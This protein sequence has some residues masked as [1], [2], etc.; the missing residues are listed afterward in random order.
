MAASF[1][2]PNFFGSPPL[3]VFFDVWHSAPES[4]RALQ[5]LLATWSGVFPQEVVMSIKKNLEALFP[6]QSQNGAGYAATVQVGGCLM[7]F[8][9][10]CLTFLNYKEF[11]SYLLFLLCKQSLTVNL[12]VHRRLCLS[13]MTRAWDRRPFLKQLQYI[14]LP[15]R[16]SR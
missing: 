1:A 11:K 9:S 8:G 14:Q 4:Q 10:A 5:K 16:R 3:Q 13:D 15:Q 6:Q 7:T 2:L 12:G